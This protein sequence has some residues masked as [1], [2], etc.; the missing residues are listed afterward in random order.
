MPEIRPMRVE[1]A[2]AVLD[3]A[4]AA[5]DAM[6]RA[7]GKEPEPPPDPDTI[8]PRHA[9]LVRTDPG[10]AWVAEDDGRL[11]GC[12]LAILREGVWGLSLLVVRPEYQSAGVGGELLRRA[13]A[14]GAGARGRI[15]LSS[16][17]PRALRSYSRLGLSGHPAFIASGEPRGVTEP[18]GIRE[19]TADDLPFL[20]TVSRHVRGAAHGPD[21]LTL[22]E[23][24]ATLLVAERGFAVVREGTLRML[25]ALDDEGAAA[26]LRAALARANGHTSV[27]WITARQAWAVPVCLDAGLE[28]RL[29]TG[30][31][32]VGGDVGPFT[33][34]L[35]SGAFL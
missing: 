5:F 23:M 9:N 1:D 25:A 30:A 13:A 17:D 6:S 33:P 34:Y 4:G 2:D 16:R 35:P 19:G 21:L 28:L 11:V 14:Y 7:H 20:D 29:D 22:L 31:V 3:V 32:F 18:A 12:S 26:L 24:G 8:R 15:I 10:G 27:D